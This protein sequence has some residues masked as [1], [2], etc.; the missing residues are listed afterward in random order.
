M[1]IIQFVVVSY[2]ISGQQNAC[3][4]F[5]VSNCF[6]TQI[7][8]VQMLTCFSPVSSPAVLLCGVS[9]LFLRFLSSSPQ[10]KQ[11]VSPCLKD[12]HW[13]ITLPYLFISFRASQDTS[14]TTPNDES[15]AFLIS[16]SPHLLFHPYLLLLI[17]TMLALFPVLKYIT[18]MAAFW[19]LSSTLL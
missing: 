15:T 12:T 19:S 6:V 11:S 7:R 18:N 9:I 10:P 14:S 1:K 8:R 5:K 16:P 2:I 13:F 4:C 17:L 3:C